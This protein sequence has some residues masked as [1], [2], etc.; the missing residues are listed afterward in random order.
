[1]HVVLVARVRDHD[2][3]GPAEAARVADED[4]PRAGGDEAVDEILREP[5][6][7][8]VGRR[9]RAQLPVEPREVDVDVEPVLVRDV[10][11]GHRP[12]AL[13]ADVADRRGAVHPGFAARYAAATE[14]IARIVRS[15][16]YS[17]FGA[18]GTLS[19]TG[20]Q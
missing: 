1:M 3:R 9:R 11:V 12:A 13:A 7:D 15:F 17:R 16:P 19:V 6:V 8:L 2:S 18:F 10:L 20:S 4:H 5:A 14:T